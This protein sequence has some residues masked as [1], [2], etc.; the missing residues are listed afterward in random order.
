MKDLDLINAEK[1]EKLFQ[2]YERFTELRNKSEIKNSLASN[3]IR[4][5]IDEAIEAWNQYKTK[6]VEERSTSLPDRWYSEIPLES[7]K[8]KELYAAAFEKASEIFK[9][10]K[11][12]TVTD[13]LLS[14]SPSVT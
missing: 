9:E 13:E 5:G 8:E 2:N 3:I 10:N 11:F 14:E 12:S 4:L 7:D 1:V 6:A